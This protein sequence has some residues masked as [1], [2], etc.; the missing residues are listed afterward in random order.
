MLCCNWERE[1]SQAR[2]AALPQKKYDQ[3]ERRQE[4]RRCFGLAWTCITTQ[5]LRE[6]ERELEIGINKHFRCWG[7]ERIRQ[8][9]TNLNQQIHQIK[10]QNVYLQIYEIDICHER[11]QLLLVPRLIQC[12]HPQ[13]FKHNGISTS[14]IPLLLGQSLASHLP[15]RYFMHFKHTTDNI[16]S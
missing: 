6:R 7:Q 4:R 10:E 11:Y 14:L 5:H 8:K 16:K 3:D 9:C 2:A 15:S 13:L 12:H 1:L